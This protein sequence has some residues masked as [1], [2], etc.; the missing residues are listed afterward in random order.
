MTARSKEASAERP[1]RPGLVCGARSGVHA[2]RAVAARRVGRGAGG[3]KAEAVVF[4]REGGS[5]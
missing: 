3:R 1:E 5:A 4:G 2:A